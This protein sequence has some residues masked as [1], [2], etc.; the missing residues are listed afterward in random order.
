M[1]IQGFPESFGNGVL[2][3]WATVRPGRAAMVVVQRETGLGRAQRARRSALA[4]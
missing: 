3:A 1:I 2:P 4:P